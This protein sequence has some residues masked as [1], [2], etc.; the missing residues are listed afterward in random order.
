[1]SE[2][3]YRWVVI[4]HVSGRHSFFDYMDICHLVVHMASDPTIITHC[5]ATLKS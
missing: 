3:H 2:A 1:M 5:N 4:H